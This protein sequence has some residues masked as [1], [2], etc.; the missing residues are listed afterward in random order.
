MKTEKLFVVYKPT[1]ES[2][3]A[4]I[5]SGDASTIN[6]LY[7]QFLGGLKPEMIHGFYIKKS[8][9][10]KEAENLY[11]Q[12]LATRKEDNPL[13]FP[14]KERFKR[15]IDEFEELSM[16]YSIVVESIGGVTILSGKKKIIY[17]TDH[18]SGDITARISEY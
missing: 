17:T 12:L 5:F 16:K 9:A 15:F 6:S 2:E 14:T 10:E 13:S 3:R 11:Q 18:T 4:D 7:N 1:F 8:E